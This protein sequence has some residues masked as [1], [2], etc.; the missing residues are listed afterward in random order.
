M[1]RFE[2]WTIDP[3][4]TSPYREERR[5]GVV[6]RYIPDFLLHVENTPSAI[7]AEMVGDVTARVARFGANPGHRR[8]GLLYTTLLKSESISSSMIEGYQTP[9]SEVLLAE[10]APEIVN[11]SAHVI[12]Q[13]L[14]ALRVSLSRLNGVWTAEAID[15]VLSALL[16]SYPQGYRST[17]VRVG[18]RSLFRAAFVPPPADLVPALM[19]DL[20]GYANSGPESVVTKAALI[21]AQFETVHPYND[22]N[23]RTGRALVHALFA[24][25]GL[26]PGAI[27][28]VSTV[29][30]VRSER[31][32]GALTA[33]RY[34][35][36]ADQKRQ[37]GVNAFVETFAEALND[38]VTLAE[39]VAEDV[40]AIEQ[41]WDQR[42]S[43]FR[44][45]S[46]AMWAVRSF[47]N[48]P[49]LTV[50]SLAT[51]AGVTRAAAS[52][53]ISKLVDVGILAK[54][55]GKY[56]KAEVFL[57]H[58]VL[59]LLVTAERRAASP[60]FDTMISRPAIP[61]PAPLN[62]LT[63]VCGESMPRVGARCVLN[64]GH[65]GGHKSRRYHGL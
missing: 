53:A 29:L 60:D 13:N 49:A 37:E 27:L 23:G 15:G 63:M 44:Q 21:H 54:A 7:I 4:W 62:P 64:R 40:V 32:I 65:A 2:K 59:E 24:R 10:F 30:K 12:H 5:G 46:T 3:D 25:S 31:Y 35:A 36:D 55:E 41:E 17:Q 22:G 57:A 11:K 38:S 51:E 1:A 18:G 19:D 50:E 43:R 8:L 16:P 20:V 34:D 28:P 9:P 61:T 42:T 47:P 33:Y 26:L 48:Q 14:L 45:D 56:R 39:L 6:R 52:R 58:Q